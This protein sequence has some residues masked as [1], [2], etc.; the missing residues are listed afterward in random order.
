M[1]DLRIGEASATGAGGGAAAVADDAAGLAGFLAPLFAA[2][3]DAGLFG[4][5]DAAEPDA[6]DPLDLRAALERAAADLPPGP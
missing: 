5:R 6:P 4:L 1:T 3:E 2:A